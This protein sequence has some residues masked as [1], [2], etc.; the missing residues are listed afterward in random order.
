[1]QIYLIQF[2]IFPDDFKMAGVTPIFKEGEKGDV[3][4]YRPISILCTVARGFE[5]FLYNQLHQY[6]VQHNVLCS[7]PWGFR[8]LHSTALALIDCTDNWKLNIDKGKL[9]STILL[10]I[11][12][13]FDTIDHDI[14][15]QKLSHYGVTNLELK[16]F[17]S[18][19]HDR[20]RCCDVNEHSSTFETIRCGVPQGS[21]LSPILFIIYMNDLPLCIE[22][23]HVTIYA[24][25]TSSSSCIKSTNDIISEVIPNMRSLM[26]WLRANRLSL[27]TLKTEFMFSGTSVNILKIGELLAIRVD[28]HTIKTRSQSQISWHNNR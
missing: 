12:K 16:F 20:K 14:L 3:S 28:G 7:N 25:D 23:G 5:K 4:N 17:R 21:I 8:S 6:L 26:E 24:D 10:D 15:L 11:K 22:N 27:N 13:A 18:Y 1:M 2:G 19:L 9:N